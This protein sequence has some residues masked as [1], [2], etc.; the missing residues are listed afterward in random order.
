MLEM[1]GICRKAVQALVLACVFGANAEG[2]RNL[3]TNFDHRERMGVDLPMGWAKHI[4]DKV[5]TQIDVFPQA[6]GSVRFVATGN[7]W[8]LYEQ[9]NLTLVPGGKYR[10][11][12]EVKTQ[13]LGGAPVEIFLHDSKWSWKGP[14]RGPKFPDDTKGEWVRQEAVV[15]MCDNPGATMHTLSIGCI[16]G[17]AAPKVDF[18]L[19]D[20]RLE[21]LDEATDRASA[22]VDA[23]SR[24]KLVARIV[25]VDPLLANVNAD[26]ARITFYWPGAPAC[27]VSRC[28][29][30]SRFKGTKYDKPVSARFDERGYATVRY[31]RV[32]PSKYEIEVEVFD[33]ATN[34]LAR[35]EYQ[36]AVTRPEKPLTAGR[37]LN[38]FVTALVDQPLEDGVVAFSRAT[39]GWVWMSFEGDIGNEAVG[40]LDDIAYP[41]VRR[42]DGESRIEAQ[43]FVSA[44]AHT[45][46]IAGAKPGGRL[47][48][49][50]VKTI[51]GKLPGMTTAPS[52]CYRI[53]FR[54]TLP[55]CNRFGIHTHMNTSTFRLSE[56]EHVNPIYAGYGYER[57]MRMFANVRISPQGPI[58]DDY[59]AT[60]KALTEGPWT[61]GFSISV[62]ENL[63]DQSQA[64]WRTGNYSEAAWKMVALRPEQSINLFYADTARGNW[65]DCPA[66]SA[67]EV[68]ATVN[69]GNGTGLICPEFYASVRETPEQLDRVLD[70][71]A[72]FVTS[73]NEMVPAS[74]GK[75]VMYGA[76]YVQIGDWSN[77]VA[78]ATDIKAHYAKM[79]RAFATDQRFADC[80]GV[81]CGGMICGG[82]ELLRW[83]AKCV[84]YYALEGGTGDLAEKCGFTWTPGFV[85]NAD[86]DEGL[87]NW[88]AKGEIAA[89]RLKNYGARVQSRK[90]IPNGYGDGV[91]VFTTRQGHPN[92]LSQDI[93]GLRP[94]KTYALL[95]CVADRGDILAKGGKTR[96]LKSPLAFSARLEGAT[97]LP[98]LRYETVSAT[99]Q[100]IG[101]RL[102]RYVFRADSGTARLVFVDR[103]DDGS[104]APDGFQQV[105]NYVSFMPYYVESPDEPAEIAAA[106][107]WKDANR[108]RNGKQ[109]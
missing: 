58:C 36:I 24:E 48:I 53:G 3:V 55:F 109:K 29:V 34:R 106:L 80:A 4:K 8:A 103:K 16:H 28:R 91:A 37:R 76:S 35:N 61:D 69:S 100:K 41:V 70:A 7:P 74:R 19:R 105:L 87:T 20:L 75:I 65:F 60:W 98:N 94:G 9:R 88:T 27:G 97:E 96:G 25:P 6:D 90:A 5:T 12:Y 22:P 43:R 63:V 62:D 85:K 15:T 51:W 93:S 13:G 33:C 39:P 54:Y 23:K 73:A 21:A 57:G 86:M 68:A 82:E 31:G 78:P 64:P 104:S 17:Q 95:F 77:Y 108:I 79:Y 38:N 67:S 49:N 99:R 10:L 45:L 66:L 30:V 11:S 32:W 89:E 14:Q 72:K 42:R 83:M 102:L 84:R 50:A 101:M 107:G 56:R 44:G 26:D 92:E 59:E 2:R 71:Y 47:R 52:A 46:R 40:Y 81:G 1:K 18:A